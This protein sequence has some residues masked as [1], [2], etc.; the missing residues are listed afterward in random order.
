VAAAKTVTEGLVRAIA[1]EVAAQRR[2]GSTYGADAT[3]GLGSAT[4]ITLNKRA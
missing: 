3:T 2:Q 1:E 4:A